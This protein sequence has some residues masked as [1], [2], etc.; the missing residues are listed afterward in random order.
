MA[1][2]RRGQP[3]RPEDLP[4]EH[5]T[6][7]MYRDELRLLGASCEACRRANAEIAARYRRARGVIPRGARDNRRSETSPTKRASKSA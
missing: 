2:T 6:Y 7:I 1:Q 5:G 3:A 4:G